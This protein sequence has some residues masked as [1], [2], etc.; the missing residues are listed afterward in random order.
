MFI[1]TL[2]KFL[3]KEE[4]NS[5]VEEFSKVNL[6]TAGVGA[7]YAGEK[8][9]KVRDSEVVMVEI[10][11]IK[12]KLESVLKNEIQFKGYELDEIEKFQFTKYTNGGHYDW[13]TDTGLNFEYRFCS[14]VIQLNDTY[15]GGELLYKDYDS[16]EVEFEK[17]IGNL[18]IFS[19]SA[20]HKVNPITNG[21]RYS[22]VSWIKLK[23][24]SGYKK[25]LL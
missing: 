13:H 6:F 18:F 1:R 8:L 14:I 17:G 20:E 16:T 19:S 11:W 4:C 10:D 9:K 3:T 15:S 22:L 2:N 25:T 12:S 23:E 24:I 21:I 7:D 5:I